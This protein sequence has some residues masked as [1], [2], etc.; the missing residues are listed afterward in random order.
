M[1]IWMD[2]LLNVIGYVGFIG[3]ATFNKSAEPVPQGNSESL[4]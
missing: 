2:V 1:P 4:T 3:V